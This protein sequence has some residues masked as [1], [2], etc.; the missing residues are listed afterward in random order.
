MPTYDPGPPEPF[1]SRFDA[2]PDYEP[3][4]AH[5]WFDWGPVFYRGRLDGSA[6]VLCVASDPGP[7]ERIAGRTLVG[8]AGQ[9]VQGFLVKLGLTRSYLCLNAFAYAL[10]PATAAPVGPVLSEPRL[11]GLAEQR[12]RP[13]RGRPL[14][15][16]S[17]SVSLAQE[18]LDLWPGSA[19]LAVVEIAHPSSRGATACST[20]GGRR[21]SS[22]AR[23]CRPIPTA[24]RPAQLRREV[25]R[26][27]LR[28]DPPPRP[29]VRR[30]VVA[31]RRRLGRQGTPRRNEQRLAPVAGRPSH[32]DLAR[33][34]D[35]SR[36][37]TATPRP[38]G[39]SPMPKTVTPGT[40]EIPSVDTFDTNAIP[41]RSTPRPRVPATARRPARGDRTGGRSAPRLPADG[42]SCTGHAVAARSTTSSRRCG[43]GRGSARTCSTASPAGTTSSRATRTPA[44]RCVARSRAGST[45][46]SRSRG[47]GRRSKMPGARPGRPGEPRARGATARW[48]PSTASTRSA[49]TTSS[50]RSPS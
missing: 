41:T 14:S 43:A 37:P 23:S 38:E 27:R 18:A 3:F 10:I 21:S 15:R 22:C 50:R 11:P 35:L 44:R 47:H 5:F 8:D 7:T 20:S 36:A 13:G 25:P 39:A 6:R 9:R 45:T 28:A 24:T 2:L 46:A 16:S 49:S 33:P 40:I 17:R 30:P 12:V 31:G 34:R 42:Q 19:G 26:A 29:A 32:A 1:H 48:A 4:R